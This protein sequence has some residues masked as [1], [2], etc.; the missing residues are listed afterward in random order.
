MFTRQAVINLQ[1]RYEN[2]PEHLEAL[3]TIAQMFVVLQ[4]EALQE[5]AAAISNFNKLYE[6]LGQSQAGAEVYRDFCMMFVQTFWCYMFATPAL[7]AGL[8]PWDTSR[9]QD[10]LGLINLLAGLPEKDKAR[11][12]EAFLKLHTWPSSVDVGLFLRENQDWL[13]LI[14]A[15]QEARKRASEPPPAQEQT[16]R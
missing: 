1:A 8:V 9:A 15:D 6:Y 11:M 3:D 7:A 10:Y 13:A 12:F 5:Q 2:S 16:P 4:V 14:K